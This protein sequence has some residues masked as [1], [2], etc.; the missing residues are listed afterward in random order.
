MEV[1]KY[2]VNISF[3]PRRAEKRHRQLILLP[4]GHPLVGGEELGESRL[5]E[6][7]GAHLAESTEHSC[8]VLLGLE[9]TCDG[10]IEDACVFFYQQLLGSL[11]PCPQNKL[12]GSTSRRLTQHLREVRRAQLCLLGHL[13]QAHVFMEVFIN[14]AGH[15]AELHRR[16]TST[17]MTHSD[18]QYSL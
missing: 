3:A 8:K 17:V 1:H 15:P 5:T 6:L 18:L 4:Q 13:H 9:S 11:H 12:M 7:C 10:Y 16:E 2:T 14:K